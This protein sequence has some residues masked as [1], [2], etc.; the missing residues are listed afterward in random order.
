MYKQDIFY[1]IKDKN[2]IPELLKECIDLSYR[3]H[4]D[5]LYKKDGTFSWS[6]V[7]HYRGLKYVLNKLSIN[8]HFVFIYRFALNKNFNDELETG[9]SGG[10][11]EYIFIWLDIGNLDYLVKKYKLTIL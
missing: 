7:A 1:K 8:E 10:N 2:R 4:T 6:R 5:T 3:V 9:I 11:S